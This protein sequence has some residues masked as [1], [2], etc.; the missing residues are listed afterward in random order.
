MRLRAGTAL[1]TAMLVVGLL[2]LVGLTGGLIEAVLRGVFASYCHQRPE[3]S[4][5]LFGHTMVV[6]SRC[7]GVYS[8]ILLGALVPLPARFVPHVRWL[9]GGAVGLALVDVA[10]QDLGL[11][12][13]YHPIRVATGILIGAITAGWVSA[14]LREATPQATCDP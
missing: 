11:H 9:L 7:F 10:T 1:R 8:G 6:C 3:R 2:P 13:P 14:K 4:L 12:A 5:V